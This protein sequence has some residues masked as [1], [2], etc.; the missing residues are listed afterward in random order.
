M[1]IIEKAAHRT[2]ARKCGNRARL[3]DGELRPSRIG[4][5]SL[6]TGAVWDL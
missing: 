5:G 2:V 1:D 4:R 6:I 3:P